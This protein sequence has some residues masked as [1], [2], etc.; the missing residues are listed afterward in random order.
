MAT[1]G[2]P[3]WNETTGVCEKHGLPQVPCPQCVATN[4]EDMERRPDAIE[5]DGIPLS[6]AS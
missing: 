5:R 4:D 3:Y 6:V 2:S 1:L